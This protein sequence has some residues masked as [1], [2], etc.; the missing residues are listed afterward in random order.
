M[1]NE[2]A[3]RGQV[4]AA[5]VLV[6]TFGCSPAPAED[7]IP[8]PPAPV[9][10]EITVTGG[11]IAG[12]AVDGIK[13]FKH[14]P[15]AAPPI[16]DRRWAPPAPVENWTGIRDTST[17]GPDCYQPELPVALYAR[18][19][20]PQSEDCLALNVWTPAETVEDQ[21]PVMVWIH[22][23]ALIYGSGRLEAENLAARG[24]VVVGV[25]YRLGAFGYLAHPDLSAEHPAG[26]SG[27]QG[28]QDQV[29]ALRWV[30]D[31]IESFGGDADNVTIFGESAGSLS[32]SALMTSQQAA[33]LF[34]RAI[35]QSGSIFANQLP[36]RS[37]D[38]DEAMSSAEAIGQAFGRALGSDDAATELATM[39]AA[40]A[41]EILSAWDTD[42]VFTDYF[43]LPV[44]DGW[45]FD[46]RAAGVFA[47]GAHNDVP[48]MLGSNADEGSALAEAVAPD[49]VQSKTAYEAWVRSRLGDFADRALELYPAATDLDVF[50]AV[51][52][53]V[54]D[55]MFTWSMH[56]WATATANGEAPAY[57]YFFSRVP[58]IE[59]S[60]ELGAYHA[61]EI[62]YVFANVTTE[63]YQSVDFDLSAAM[64]DTWVRFAT[65]GDP[66]GASLPRWAPFDA[67]NAD[68]LEF[69]DQIT[70]GNSLR[71]EKVALWT[72][73]YDAGGQP[74]STSRPATDEDSTTDG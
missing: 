27:N 39:R 1:T 9:G 54:C 55:E 51:S 29:A 10:T 25:N 57:L 26:V 24:V 65:T 2:L 58:P 31:N 62:P 35:G 17:F 61:A 49:A 22:G 46:D 69:G 63:P 32:V 48:L 5:W 36:L 30:K 42:P 11:M 38:G 66:N 19:L 40:S 70:A 64:A 28:F 15:Y 45:F 12:T 23:G 44:I 73:Y 33:G 4:L 14:I 72:A 21:L 47:A 7:P 71:A 3:R 53:L 6:M 13:S 60:D 37:T 8:P 50:N 74:P 56:A 52:N 41:M 67:A 34:H 43:S 20:E 68:Y 18:E 59:G 16:G